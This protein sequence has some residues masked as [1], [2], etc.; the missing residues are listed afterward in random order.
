LIEL[1]KGWKPFPYNDDYQ[2]QDKRYEKK[3]GFA[4]RDKELSSRHR[5]SGVEVVK[6]IGKKVIPGQIQPHHDIVPHQVHVPEVHHPSEP[7]Y[8]VR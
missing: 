7:H 6:M 1:A 5:S 3:G 2:C 4:L 8:T